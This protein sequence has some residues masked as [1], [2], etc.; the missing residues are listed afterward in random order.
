MWRALSNDIFDGELLA[1]SGLSVDPCSQLCGF[2]RESVNH[3]VF[4]CSIAKQVRVLCNIPTPHDRINENFF[5][6][7]ISS[8][9]QL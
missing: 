5:F 1:K 2:R 8:P 9:A 3:I 4:T 7:K 6:L